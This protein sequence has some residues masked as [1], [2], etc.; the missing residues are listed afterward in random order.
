M[1]NIKNIIKW[2]KNLIDK[3]L[4]KFPPFDKKYLYP[5]FKEALLHKTI[6]FTK[7]HCYIKL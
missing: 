2:F 4:Y 1:K 3:K 5:S 7:G 6:Q